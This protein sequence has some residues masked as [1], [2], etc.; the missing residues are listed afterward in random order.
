KAEAKSKALV[1]EANKL[2]PRE[3]V[4]IPRSYSYQGEQGYRTVYKS[5]QAAKE[6][7][8]QR[9]K[10]TISTALKDQPT[11]VE[12]P[13]GGYS[14]VPHK[15]ATINKLKIISPYRIQDDD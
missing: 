2:A 6:Q 15:I 7:W 11:I 12:S 10:N 8:R 9:A 13:K 1:K 14:V 4:N 5:P 3:V